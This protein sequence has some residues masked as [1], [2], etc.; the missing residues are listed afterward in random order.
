MPQTKNK[1][2]ENLKVL[3]MQQASK[4]FKNIFSIL[5]LLYSPNLMGQTDSSSY[6][7]NTVV[8]SKT[9][10]QAIKT[11]ES[12]QGYYARNA[13]LI[14]MP[15][16]DV[17]LRSAA[18]SK[19]AKKVFFE[20]FYWFEGKTKNTKLETEFSLYVISL[21]HD[22]EFSN[23]DVKNQLHYY[24]G[25]I[26][27]NLNEYFYS[28]K[29]M[30][31]FLKNGHNSFPELVQDNYTLNAMTVLSLVKLNQNKFSESLRILNETIDSAIAKNNK[32]WIGITK[33]NIGNV[34]YEEGNFEEAIKYLKEDCKTSIEN[35]E[36]GSALGAFLLLKNIYSKQGN[37]VLYNNCLDSSYLIYQKIIKDNPSNELV[38]L[39][40]GLDL[41]HS[42]AERYFI[43]KD[44]ANA[45]KFYK[46]GYD[47]SN[48]IDKK[49]KERLLKK[50]IEVI[51][52]G[53]NI[54]RINE[55]NKE[56]N[57]KKGILL[58]SL[59]FIILIIGLF[60]VY[61][62]FYGR[63]K[64]ANKNLKEIRTII[65]QQNLDLE[66]I[67]TDKDLLFSVISKDLLSIA[68]KQHQIINSMANNTIPETDY[69]K[70]IPLL[71]VN[72]SAFIATLEDVS[73]QQEKSKN[74]SGL[75]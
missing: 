19:Y 41:N 31:L 5:I 9:I 69:D 47:L 20:L 72:S 23:P 26:Y 51:E 64:N 45:S 62:L 15:N 35:N 40:E 54:N 60:I 63:L 27:F 71:L 17:I 46:M 13:H 7:V 59:I 14:S 75:F 56:I 18:K 11:E 50:T 29:H 73:K 67:N 49:Q 30:K 1:D 39:K 43:Q 42:L 57:K 58:F 74:L 12:I 44:Y 6:W 66:K 65:S 21:E 4:L 48:K 36:I 52:I 37:I 22:K 53:K 70:F 28:E 24:Y 55:L 10:E 2:F 8:E 32:A 25:M 3:R 16:V 68:Q 38:Y 33:G 34:F 61:M